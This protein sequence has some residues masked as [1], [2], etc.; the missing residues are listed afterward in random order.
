M[1]FVPA[2]AWNCCPRSP[3]YAAWRGAV[4]VDQVEVHSQLLTQ[5][6]ILRLAS[7]GRWLGEGEACLAGSDQEQA[8]AVERG[9]TTPWVRQGV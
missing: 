2:I 6:L 3:E 4:D 8:D 5:C 9:G 1:E 7:L